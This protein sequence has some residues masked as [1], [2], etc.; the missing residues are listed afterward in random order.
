MRTSGRG[1]QAP[2]QSKT[3]PVA[4]LSSQQ[5]HSDFNSMH[6]MRAVPWPCH[7]IPVTPLFSGEIFVLSRTIAY[8]C[9][10][11]DGQSKTW[12]VV[13]N[14]PNRGRMTIVDDAKKRTMTTST[15]CP[16]LPYL[17]P[18]RKGARQKPDLLT[19][20]EV[21]HAK[22]GWLNDGGGLELEDQGRIEEMGVSGTCATAKR[23][24]SAAAGRDPGVAENRPRAARPLSSTRWRWAPDPR[25][26][27]A[28]TVAGRKTFGEA[29]SELIEARRNSG[30]PPPTTAEPVA[31]DTWS[32][33]LSGRLQPHRQALGQRHR[34]RRHQAHR[35][36]RFSWN[37]GPRTDSRAGRSG[38]IEICV[39]LRHRARLGEDPQSGDMEK[40]SSTSCKRCGF[41]RLYDFTDPALDWRFDARI[42]GQI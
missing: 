9:G 38:R 29:A 36:T 5:L 34:H 27:K 15:I 8:L 35:A 16:M 11:E 14:P 3:G 7:K 33:S 40:I 18:P 4:G 20:M 23:S 10:V 17:A 6:G 26:E 39:R 24:R 28:K 41:E 2:K 1:T 13:S 21:E 12:T 30:A 25:S 19:P 32:K 31:L 42:H 37:A 22:D